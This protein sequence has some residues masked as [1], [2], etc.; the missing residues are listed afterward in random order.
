MTE[1]PIHFRGPAMSAR[2]GIP[3]EDNSGAV[4]AGA[5]KNLADTFF[6]G[7]AT[8]EAK[9]KKLVDDST[10][11]RAMGAYTTDYLVGANQ[12]KKDNMENPEMAQQQL[13]EFRGELKNKF[14]DGMSGQGLQQE[15]AFD[16]DNVNLQEDI[17]DVAWKIEQSQLISQ[18][19]YTDRISSDAA[20]VSQTPS[21]EEYL[22]KI[23]QFQAE[24]ENGNKLSQAFGSL[25]AGQQVLDSGM[26]SITRGF[27]SGK[28]SREESFEAAQHLLRGDFDPFITSEV[29]AELIK[30]VDQAQ[31]GEIKR[32]N[33]MQAATAAVDLFETSK[34]VLSNDID[35]VGLEE[36]ISASSF[37]LIQPGLTKER[38]GSLEKQQNLLERLRDVKLDRIAI[39]A[40][41]DIETKAELLSDYQFLIDYEEGQNS[42]NGTLEKTLDFQRK[43]TEKF[44]EGKLSA[45]TYD[46]WMTF[47]KTAIQNDITQGMREGGSDGFNAPNKEGVLGVGAKSP[48][49][50]TKKVRQH[51]RDLLKNSNRELGRE[52]AVDVLDFYM[53]GI[54]DQLGGD[55][56]G[57][58]D[59]SDETHDNIVKNAKARATLKTMGFPMYLTVGDKLPVNA[60][61][62]E[63]KGFD[64]DGMPQ[65]EIQ[66]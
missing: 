64:K 56:S 20:T 23:D 39:T 37:A 40:S 51:L 1:I 49:S 2:T 34:D 53:D 21:Y 38:K 6:S 22:K 16:I 4:I 48:L 18:K 13:K 12:I 33:F 47:A 57:L 15:F 50:E 55:L 7:V 31:A 30:K 41:D 36:R 5:V 14:V 60:M 58:A 11:A 44:Y 63:I 46:K 29:K 54:N 61:A 26:E 35:I 19:N 66:E 3:S 25:K 45:T 24:E 43:A 42:L 28:M 62:Y 8:M 32:S 9:S 65:I 27:I 10:R 17:R 59:M 52:H